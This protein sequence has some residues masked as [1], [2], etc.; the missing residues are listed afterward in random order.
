MISIKSLAKTIEATAAKSKDGFMYAMF[1]SSN[2]NS[3]PARSKV[4]AEKERHFVYSVSLELLY[5]INGLREIKSHGFD[6]SADL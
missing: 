1:V 5:L 2:A 6:F 4:L 3:S